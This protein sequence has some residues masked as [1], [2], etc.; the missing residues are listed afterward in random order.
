MPVPA[1]ITD[2]AVAA[3]TNS[4][5]GTEAV[6]TSTGP[7]EYFRAH[8]AIVRRLHAKGADVAS[9]ATVDLGAINDGSYVKITGTTAITSFGTIA[10]GV[11]RTLLFADALT[12]TH[13]AAKIILPGAANIVTVAEDVAV[14]VSEG[15][16]LWRCKSYQRKAVPPSVPLDASVVTAKIADLNVT[17]AKIA[18]GAVTTVKVA[19]DAVTY[20]KI[21][22]VSATDKI[23]GRVSAGAG[24][25]EEIACTPFARTML[26]DAGA[27]NL[28]ST[29]GSL[30]HGT[31]TKT[32]AYTVVEADRGN[33]IALD[34]TFTLSLTA[35]AT[36]DTFVFVAS[37]VGT[38]VITIDPDGTETIDGVA[39]ITL[40]PG[41]S[42]AIT[43][44]ASMWRTWGRV[45]SNGVIGYKYAETGAVATGTTLVP[46][47][48]TIPQN[49]EGDQYLSIDYAAKTT[50]NR[51]KVEVKLS[52]ASNATGYMAVSLFNGGANA[53]ATAAKYLG[54]ANAVTDITL[55]YEYTPASTATLTYTVRAGL[56][57]ANTT[58]LNGEGGARLYGGVLLSNIAITEFKA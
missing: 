41:E 20:A 44:D 32:A 2:L 25:I 51:V 4:P 6:T 5:A 43:G 9:A 16:G 45:K 7:D 26:D 14:F 10:A 48:D 40:H 57:N 1:V 27:K 8:A 33:L 31:K 55:M 56:N 18:D 13:D 35:A 22:N 15:A 50:T 29:I 30:G 36:L 34:G 24:D 38:G 17:T 49:T 28:L 54:T 39:T 3:A 21:Q 58:T 52:I 11:E 23:L 47:D 37:N 19:D 42:T 53:L 46:K 12:L